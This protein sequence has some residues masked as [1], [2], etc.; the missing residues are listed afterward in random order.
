MKTD[1]LAIRNPAWN[2]FVQRIAIKAAEDLGIKSDAEIVRAKI[3]R[4]CL[5]AVAASLT[6]YKEC[7]DWSYLAHLLR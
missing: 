1:K 2:K 6:P 4:V 5:W 7:V 3:D